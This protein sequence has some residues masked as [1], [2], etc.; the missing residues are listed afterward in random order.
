MEALDS[1]VVTT[2]VPEYIGSLRGG[3]EGN[4]GVG[5]RRIEGL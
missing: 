2:S 4:W 3:A 1:F 5:E